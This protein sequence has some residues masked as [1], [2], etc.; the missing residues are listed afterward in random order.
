MR[1]TKKVSV[2]P[3][4]LVGGLLVEKPMV[5]RGKVV[6]FNAGWRPERKFPI[7]MAGFAVSLKHLLSKPEAKFSFSSQGGFQESDF[8]SLLVSLDE[9]EPMAN[10][11]T[12]VR[13]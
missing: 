12:K 7:D 5:E 9:L 4:G 8:L 6:G 3:V 1:R 2:W 13:Q 10:N 11:C